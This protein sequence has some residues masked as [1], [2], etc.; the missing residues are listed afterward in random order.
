[1]SIG[2]TLQE[3]V[4]K[5]GG[6]LVDAPETEITIVQVGTLERATTNQISFLA[7]PK[8]KKV[9]EFT[10]A[11]AVIVSPK[12]QFLTTKPKIVT[13]N[14]YAYFAKITQYFNPTD[15]IE[16]GIHPRAVVHE[17]A[18][19]SSSS[20]IGANVVI[21]K[22]VKIGERTVI[23]ANCSIEDNVTIGDDCIIY[24][25]VIIYKDCII[26]NRNGIHGGAII[27]A[28]GF[29]LALE[30]G[31]WLKIP[32]IGR[33]VL[34]DDVEVGANTTIDRGALDDTVIETGVKLD[35]QIQIAHN[36]RIGEHTAIAGCVGI[37][38]SA[39]IGKHCTIGGGA[40]ILGHLEITD[41]VD[42]SAGSLI[43][44]SIV[45]AG[46]YTSVMP[47]MNHKDWQHNAV[48]LRQ[49]G[50]LSGSIQNLLEKVKMLEEIKQNL[51]SPE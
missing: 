31:K 1:M 49:L 23:H 50:N 51:D 9:L 21:G 25:N 13:S 6:E 26:G 36:V 33:V 17:T 32:Q 43:T 5:F 45:E 28:D 10:E 2:L 4:E 46:R 14:P 30:D 18:T 20:Q 41:H 24:A 34:H 39:K 22:N 27:G 48:H 44:K 16:A 38:G 11:G 47:F 35:N 7:N 8:Y 15:E 37:A 19:V 29:G 42:V 40:I 3:L 12:V